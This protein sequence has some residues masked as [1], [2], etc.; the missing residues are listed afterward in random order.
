VI[1]VNGLR[2]RPRARPPQTVPMEA[3]APNGR[4]GGKKS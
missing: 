3:Q 2:V 1:V 4:N